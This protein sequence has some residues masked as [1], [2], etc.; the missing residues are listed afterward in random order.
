VPV[1]KSGGERRKREKGKREK[2]ILSPRGRNFLKSVFRY[3]FPGTRI[4]ADDTSLGARPQY[5]LKKEGI[6]DGCLRGYEISGN[7]HLF[8]NKEN[9]G[10]S[11][12]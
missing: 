9:Y 3:R 12:L 1:R 7:N 8:K 5:E 11:L 6:H 10:S 2:V 4:P